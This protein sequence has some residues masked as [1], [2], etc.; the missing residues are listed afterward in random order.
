[1]TVKETEYKVSVTGIVTVHMCNFLANSRSGGASS[2]TADSPLWSQVSFLLSHPPNGIWYRNKR[3]RRRRGAICSFTGRL[4]WRWWNQSPCCGW[5]PRLGWRSPRLFQ[6]SGGR[7][8]SQLHPQAPF[9]PSRALAWSVECAQLQ[10]VLLPLLLQPP[11][12]LHPGTRECSRPSSYCLSRGNMPPAHRKSFAHK[13]RLCNYCYCCLSGPKTHCIKTQQN[14]DLRECMNQHFHYAAFIVPDHSRLDSFHYGDRFSV[15]WSNP[16][17][18]KI[19][20]IFSTKGIICWDGNDR[21]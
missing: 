18:N 21:I 12:G 16:A 3:S 2:K 9:S 17:K 13:P 20:I 11:A 15:T 7:G 8:R 6:P 19:W 14:L 5:S 10:P 1:M 4:G